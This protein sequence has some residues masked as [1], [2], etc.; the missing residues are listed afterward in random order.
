MSADTR[1]GVS[2]EVRM[3]EERIAADAL[4]AKQRTTIVSE[5]E[6]LTGA[7]SLGIPRGRRVSTSFN[8]DQRASQIVVTPDEATY[9]LHGAD[10]LGRALLATA[11]VP[12]NP[13][14]KP[15]SPLFQVGPNVIDARNGSAV[16]AKI[17]AGRTPKAA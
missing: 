12:H 4:A 13:R 6:D 1:F 8:G 16:L 5:A 2:N 15:D 14:I 7:L 3:R 10:N 9:S 11:T 17:R